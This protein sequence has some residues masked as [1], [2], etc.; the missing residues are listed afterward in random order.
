MEISEKKSILNKN[1]SLPNVNFILKFLSGLSAYK[2]TVRNK[3]F[4]H[5][6]KHYDKTCIIIDPWDPR[7]ETQT[8]LLND[9]S[10]IF[11]KRGEKKDAGNIFMR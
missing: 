7:K 5:S 9:S 10:T 8:F 4:S 2:V 11:I 1:S 3:W 6:L